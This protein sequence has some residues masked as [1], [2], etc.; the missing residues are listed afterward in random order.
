MVEEVTQSV[1]STEQA[2]EGASAES[3][4]VADTSWLESISDPELKGSKSLATFKDVEGLAKSYVHLEKKLGD[5]Q[6][7]EVADYKLEDYEVSV[8]EDY[9]VNADILSSIKEKASSLGVKPESFQELFKTF[10]DKE[11]EI[12]QGVRQSQ[13]ADLKVT[14][15]SLKKEWGGEYDSRLERANDTWAKLTDEKDDK[16]LDSLNPEAKLV[17]AKLMD[18]ISQKISEP[19]IGKQTNSVL[20]K[21]EAKS[22]LEKIYS[23]PNHP[24]H[25][26]DKNAVN[27]VFDLT[28]STVDEI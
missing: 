5:P 15:E 22:K 23:D 2:V 9:E 3:A 20:T 8:P 18:N 6:S 16:V 21:E 19:Q 26:G 28:R 25:R 4:N 27:E 24:Y 12:L 10:A 1:E 14:Q 17:I 7:R 13:E 11:A